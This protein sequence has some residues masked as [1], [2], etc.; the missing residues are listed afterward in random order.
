MHLVWARSAFSRPRPSPRHQRFD[1]D[2]RQLAC[3]PAAEPRQ[4]A[5]CTNEAA[6]GRDPT[7]LVPGSDR[8]RRGNEAAL[9]IVNTSGGINNNTGP[10][11]R[12]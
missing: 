7:T 11:H 4:R 8:V 10:L 6:L 3:G 9:V 12:R 2:R 1:I 5:A